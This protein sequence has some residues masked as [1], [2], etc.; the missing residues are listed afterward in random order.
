MA[1]AFPAA[2]ESS[3]EERESGKR[4]TVDGGGLVGATVFDWRDQGHHDGCI[5]TEHTLKEA[6]KRL[7]ILLKSD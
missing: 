5:E 2:E 7:L 6:L 4:A 3:C 1:A